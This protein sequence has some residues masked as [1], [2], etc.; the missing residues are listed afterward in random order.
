VLKGVVGIA[1]VSNMDLLAPVIP[2]TA[3]QG[4]S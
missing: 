3:G 1:P 2:D 4:I